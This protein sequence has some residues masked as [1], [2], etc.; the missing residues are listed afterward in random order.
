MRVRISAQVVIVPREAVLCSHLDTYIQIHQLKQRKGTI[1]M[2]WRRTMEVDWKLRFIFFS[3]LSGSI[4][5]ERPNSESPENL[6][7][8]FQLCLFVILEKW[9]LQTSVS[10]HIRWEHISHRAVGRIKRDNAFKAVIIMP[11][12][13]WVHNN[14]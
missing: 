3:P 9:F 12:T 6:G 13:D 11:G 14:C 1:C 10:L 7:F 2:V 5:V 8:V 4:Q